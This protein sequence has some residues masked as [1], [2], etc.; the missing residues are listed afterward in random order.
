MDWFI[1]AFIHWLID[2]LIWLIRYDWFQALS[3]IRLFNV[4]DLM[5]W[6]IDWLIW[7]DLI[8]FELIKC[9]I[10]LIWFELLFEWLID[11]L[12]FISF[13]F[14]SLLNLFVFY[15][16]LTLV[17]HIFQAI[18]KSYNLAHIAMWF[19]LIVWCDLK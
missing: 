13:D 2:W 16:I 7:C 12:N 17:A 15:S 5:N 14:T 18:K 19:A 8:S 6:L 10:D 4:F 1:H 9:F 3:V 11:W